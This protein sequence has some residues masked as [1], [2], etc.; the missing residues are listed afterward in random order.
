M[1]GL[2]VLHSPLLL[3]ELRTPLCSINSFLLDHLH[4]TWKTCSRDTT[5]NLTIFKG[6]RKPLSILDGSIMLRR[7][8]DIIAHAALSQC[9]NKGGKSDAYPGSV[10]N[11]EKNGSLKTHAQNWVWWYIPVTHYSRGR[12]RR[13]W[14]WGQPRQR[15]WDPVS[16][17][18]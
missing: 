11:G 13:I 14:V 4:L 6:S 7:T 1:A 15:Q 17:T 9:W 18:K 2:S 10:C 5:R 16:I 12:G 3:T 8:R